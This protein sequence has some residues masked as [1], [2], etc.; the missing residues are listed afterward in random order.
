MNTSLPST[1][2]ASRMRAW[3]HHALPLLLASLSLSIALAGPSA[4]MSLRYERAAI[5]DGEWWRLATGHL[6]HLGWSHL[7]LNLAGIALIWGLF[8][9]QLAT[10]EWWWVWLV[11][12]AAVSAGLFIFDADLSWYVGLSGVLHGLFIAGLLL[13]IR[14]DYWWGDAALLVIVLGKL[15]WEQVHGSLPGTTEMAGGNVIVAAH[16]YGAIGGAFAALPLL[17][18]KHDAPSAADAE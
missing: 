11:S 2:P 5:V 13:A 17:F 18:R 9:R 15:A 6:V 16:L 7:V 3:L 1:R 14:R 12:T 10:L 4:S 8:Q